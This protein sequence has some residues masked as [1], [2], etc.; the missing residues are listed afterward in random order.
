MEYKEVFCKIHIHCECVINMK[1][2]FNRQT[3]LLTVADKGGSVEPAVS[4]STG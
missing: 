3:H 1:R 2:Q 4:D